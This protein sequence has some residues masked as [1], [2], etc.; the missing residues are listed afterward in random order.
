MMVLVAFRS[1]LWIFSCPVV[2]IFDLV[3]YVKAIHDIC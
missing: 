3:L 2:N 1:N